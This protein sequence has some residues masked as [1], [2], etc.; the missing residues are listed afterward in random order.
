MLSLLAFFGCQNKQSHNQRETTGVSPVPN[1]VLEPENETGEQDKKDSG[2]NQAKDEPEIKMEKALRA[3]IPPG[4]KLAN[5]R[6]IMEQEGFTCEP[7]YKET[8][9]IDYVY[10]DRIDR[11]SPIS[12]PVVRRWQVCLVVNKGVITDISVST[13]LIGP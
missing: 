10:C 3:K 11:D 12:S 5:A 8:P 1:I 2:P 7:E 6:Q 9:P 13:G 4:T